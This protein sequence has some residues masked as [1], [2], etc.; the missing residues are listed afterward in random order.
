MKEMPERVSVV[1]RDVNSNTA[2]FPVDRVMS[3]T[4]TSV[5]VNE[6][7][8]RLNRGAVCEVE[9]DEMEREVRMSVPASEE[10]RKG[11]AVREDVMERV[12]VLSESVPSPTLNIVCVSA[13]PSP[14]LI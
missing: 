14:V 9:A 1:E 12:N 8:V 5:I 7:E 6:P 4:F 3:L 11:D 10:R 13:S 2:P